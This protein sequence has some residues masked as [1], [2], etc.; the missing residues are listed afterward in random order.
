M[1]GLAGKHA[2]VTGGGTGIGAE[3]AWAL[4]DAGA[5][6]TVAGRRREPL[7]ETA[8]GREAIRA[9]T[10]DVTDPVS[11]QVLFDEAAEAWG[12]FSIV[13]ANAGAADSRPFGKLTA[14]ELHNTL[15]VNLVGTF[16][17]WQPALPAMKEGG[18]GRLIAIA[19]IAGLKGA[20]YI[21]AYCAAKHGVVGLTRAL[22][23]EVAT[24]GVTVNAVCP[25]YVRT[26][27]LERTLDTIVAKTGR[28]R[29]EALAEIAAGNPQG[30]IIE[31]QEVAD[32]VLW[33]CGDGA[34]SVN[35]Q[36]IALSGG[37]P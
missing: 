9:A 11:M 32:A 4:A 33:L 1:A 7:E 5:R 29:A 28:S 35:G 27:M 20:P 3:I 19:S 12:T 8:A 22:A 14:Q 21:S 6:V 2:L 34:A 37:D 31:P 16:T 24:T 25:G 10:C 30:R 26:P 15:D 18:W 36:A 23:L 17:A 13:V